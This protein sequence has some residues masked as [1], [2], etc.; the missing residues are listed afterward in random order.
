MNT[1]GFTL[2]ELTAIIV[3]LAAIFLVSFPTLQ[4]M[5]KSDEEKKFNNMVDNLCLAGRTYIYSNI[6]E[7]NDL[8]IPENVIDIPVEMLIEYGFVESFLQNPKTKENVLND[9]LF[10]TVLEDKYLECEYIDY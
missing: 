10:Y 2:I 3:V 4:N 9:S 6:E 8:I 1:K 7:Y 5:A